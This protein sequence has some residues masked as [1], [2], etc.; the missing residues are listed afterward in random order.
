MRP[1]IGI[2]LDYQSEGTFSSR[3]HNA[4]RCAYFDAIA[5]AGGLPVAIG[6]AEG[7]ADDLLDR[8][9]GLILPGGFYPFPAGYYGKPDDGEPVH[10][11]AAFEVDLAEGALARDMPVLGICAGMQ[12]LAAVRGGTLYRNLHDVYDTEIDHLNERPAEEVAHSVSITPG[13]L[14]HAI[15][16]RKEMDVN[17]AH[18]EAVATVPDGIIANAV[19]PDGVIEGLEL[20]DRRFALGVQWHPEF[21]QAAGDPNRLLFEVHVAVA[22]GK[23]PPERAAA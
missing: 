15:T 10:P 6:Y 17:T 1:L 12:V 21:F 22:A 23:A 9:D 7:T 11:R 20:P 2:L 4:L 5:K 8:I 16:G 19:A 13:T 3:P 14:L 18:N